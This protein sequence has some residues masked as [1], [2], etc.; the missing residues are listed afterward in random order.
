MLSLL[1]VAAKT[2]A[3]LGL[4][5]EE[6]ARAMS[7]SRTSIQSWESGRGEPSVRALNRMIA[8][9]DR[10]FADQI[11]PLVREKSHAKL[12]RRPA[13]IRLSEFQSESIAGL[14]AI[15]GLDIGQVLRDVLD[16]GITSLVK[17][18]TENSMKSARPRDTR[19]REQHERLQAF[20]SQVQQGETKK[21]GSRQREGGQRS[22]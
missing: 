13:R 18:L 15:L 20:L 7:V 5:Q 16:A 2:R 6:F 21:Q 8:L 22:A 3:H 12:G 10:E 11:R 19:S 14:S 9:V 1:D 4:G 17:Q